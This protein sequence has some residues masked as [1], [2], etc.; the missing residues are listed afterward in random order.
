MLTDPTL[1]EFIR[2]MKFLYFSLPFGFETKL[3]I[4]YATRTIK[5]KLFLVQQKTVIQFKDCE[6][7]EAPF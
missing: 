1:K 6:L 4:V 3:Y 2:L 7:K 5:P